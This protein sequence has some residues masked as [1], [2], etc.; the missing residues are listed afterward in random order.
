MIRNRYIVNKTVELVN[1]WAAFEKQHPKGNIDDFCRHYLARAN[2]KPGKI[3]SEILKLEVPLDALL[4]RLMGRIVKLHSIYSA[5][6]LQGTGLVQ[7]EEFALLFAIHQ[8]KSPKKS[9]V[10]YLCLLELS[11]GTDILNRLKRNG[12]LTEFGDKEDRRSKRVKL[13]MAGERTIE[14]S[15]SRVQQLAAMMFHELNDDDIKLCIHL[16]SRVEEKFTSLWQG[17]REK[18]FPEIYADVVKGG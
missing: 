17:H 1:E 14:K 9:E 18:S 8:K 4:M 5:A 12:F 6:A 13:T 16:L 10:I 15:M 3:K 11:T 2:K 7:V